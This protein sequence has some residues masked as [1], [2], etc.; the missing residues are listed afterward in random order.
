[1]ALLRLPVL[2]ASVSWV[3][4]ADPS[5]YL[6]SGDHVVFYG[7]SITEQ[8]L[9]TLYTETYVVTRFPEM[10]VSFVH[11]GW[12]GDKVSGGH[13]GPIDKRLE[14]DV[15][16]YDPTVVT[17][18]LGMNDGGYRALDEALFEAYRNGYEHIIESLKSHVPGVRITAIQPSPFDDVTQPPRFAGGYNAVLLK[19]SEFVR[20][21][22]K[23]QGLSLADL[24]GPVVA[25]LK[26]AKT[27]DPELAKKI[28]PDRVHPGA[29]GHLLMAEALLKAWHAP[30]VVSEI[31]IDCNSGSVKASRNARVQDLKALS[32]TATENALPF[33][34]DWTDATV[35][36]AMDSS[37]FVDALN[38]EMLRVSGLQAGKWELRIDDAAVG[39]FTAQELEK[40]VNLA[41]LSTPMTKQAADVLALT[42]KHTDLHQTRWRNIQV[43]L[44]TDTTPD[45][46]T[47]MKLIDR[48]EADV[49]AQQQKAAQPVSHKF[50]LIH[51]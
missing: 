4:F 41:L 14:R 16:P 40:G 15:F 37:D 5:F 29:A 9:Y 47:V 22:A 35:K 3:L 12:G 44:E 34:I 49:V 1:M 25:S 2:L 48:L 23:R 24:N 18:M 27:K 32:W 46:E 6:K 39:S 21:L 31:E 30:P 11:S 26:R 28:I 19:Y 43:P 51:Q 36:L 45:K 42:K 17:I 7:D 38:L 10:K 8:R 50:E 13:G 20:D 33:P